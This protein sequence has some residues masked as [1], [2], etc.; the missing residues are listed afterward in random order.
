LDTVGVTK[1]FSAGIQLAR[2]GAHTAGRVLKGG[3]VPK[4]NRD[5]L[6]P[7]EFKAA[8]L[9]LTTEEKARLKLIAKW[10]TYWTPFLWKDLLHEAVQRAYSGTRKCPTGISLVRFLDQAMRSIRSE[11]MEEWQREHDP[12][13]DDRD[14]DGVERLSKE[15]AISISADEQLDFKEIVARAQKYLSEPKD[16]DALKYL[17]ALLNDWNRS[18]CMKRFQWTVT[19]YETT[20]RRFKNKMAK[21]GEL[22]LSGKERDSKEAAP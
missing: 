16:E 15:D 12:A 7:E 13:S 1:I 10:W 2:L 18:E 8:F 11:W 22:L 19:F 5:A 4:A 17:T 20:K 14:T 21:L 6:S 3:I 9:A